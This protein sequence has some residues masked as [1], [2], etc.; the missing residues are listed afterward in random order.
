[1]KPITEEQREQLISLARI[2]IS[3]WK[4]PSDKQYM[5]DLM[6]IALA[7]LTAVRHQWSNGCNLWVPRAL[8]YLAENERPGGGNSYFNTE[9]LYQL[10]RELELSMPSPLYTAPPVTVI[11]FDDIV[12]ALS[13]SEEA[14]DLSPSQQT[15]VSEDI[16]KYLNGLS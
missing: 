11:K 14:Q 12:A 15:A 9:H 5:V 6:E 10:A 2:E 1:M 8:R 3:R 7:S 13:K 4:L 16:V